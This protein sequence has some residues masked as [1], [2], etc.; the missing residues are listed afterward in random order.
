M[1]GVYSLLWDTVYIY[2][3]IYLKVPW[4]ALNSNFEFVPCPLYSVF[5]AI[6][7]PENTNSVKKGPIS[8]A[9]SASIYSVGAGSSNSREHFIG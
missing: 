4:H 9:A 8:A 2:I 5:R 1:W 7:L 6:H 3:Y